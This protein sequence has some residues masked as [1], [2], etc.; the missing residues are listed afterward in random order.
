MPKTISAELEDAIA[1]FTSICN[2]PQRKPHIE[3]FIHNVMQNLPEYLCYSL[4]CYSRNYDECKY[5]VYD[6]EDPAE[7]IEL[8][9]P[10]L[11]EAFVKMLAMQSVGELNCPQLNRVPLVRNTESVWDEFESD[12]DAD[13][14]DTFCQVAAYGEV[15][16]G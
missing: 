13:A 7:K 10:K 14:V 2:D 9:L 16:F 12:W 4:A 1:A 3:K 11:F 8:N 5:V 6:R 15:I